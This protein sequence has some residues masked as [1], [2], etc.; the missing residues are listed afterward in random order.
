MGWNLNLLHRI[1][2]NTVSAQASVYFLL[3]RSQVGDDLVMIPNA[4]VWR[5]KVTSSS[6][7]WIRD[8][9]AVLIERNLVFAFLPLQHCILCAKKQKWL[10]ATRVNSFIGSSTFFWT[11]SKRPMIETTKSWTFIILGKWGKSS[12]WKSLTSLSTWTNCLWTA[13]ILW[14]IKS[15][16]VSWNRGKN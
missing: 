8:W 9:M 11:L 13:R 6:W 12:T 7:N 14:S 15:K 3:S 4:H 5:K 1:Q 10:I 2:E 16:L